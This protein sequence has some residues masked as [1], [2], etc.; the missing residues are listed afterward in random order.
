MRRR[1]MTGILVLAVLCCLLPA[2]PAFAAVKTVSSVTVDIRPDVSGMERLPF[3]HPEGLYEAFANMYQGYTAALLK[4][5]NGETLTAQ[6]L[7][8]P[9]ADDGIRGVRFIRA[10]LESNRQGSVWTEV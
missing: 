8:F 1:T 10:C 5:L 3:G 7:D 4:N 2:K 9:N 6:D